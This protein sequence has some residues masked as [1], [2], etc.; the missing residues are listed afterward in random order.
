M[1]MEKGNWYSDMGN[2]HDHDDFSSLWNS[3]KAAKVRRSVAGCSKN[4]W[5]VGTVAT[6]MKKHMRRVAPWVIKQKTKS[7]FHQFVAD[8]AMPAC[9]S[10]DGQIDG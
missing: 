4:C 5:M 8:D 6:A 3:K 1:L 9:L 10:C 2:L 7:L